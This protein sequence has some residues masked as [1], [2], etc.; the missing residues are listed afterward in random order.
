MF[1]FDIQQPWDS[2]I[3]V[4]IEFLIGLTLS[5]QI[6]LSKEVEPAKE[7]SNGHEKPK[8]KDLKVDH[9][10]LEVGE[11]TKELTPVT[12]SYNFVSRTTLALIFMVVHMA[13]YTIVLL[14]GPDGLY[15][16]AQF[17]IQHELGGVTFWVL[18]LTA[19]VIWSLFVMR[20]S[21]IDLHVN[22]IVSK[23]F[24]L[25]AVHALGLLVFAELASNTPSF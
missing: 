12:D 17:P 4:A 19:G 22:S 18:L 25:I 8:K 21:W 13:F 3:C 2:A 23:L 14:I 9:E 15:K 6:D 7:D 10:R 5:W 11:H 1:G 16:K 20:M 24:L